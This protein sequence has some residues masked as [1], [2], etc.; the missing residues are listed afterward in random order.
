[1]PALELFLEPKKTLHLPADGNILLDPPLPNLKRVL[2][3]Q[4]SCM[5]R[6]API[7]GVEFAYLDTGAPLTIIPHRVWS[8]KYGWKAGR[9][10][11][12]LTTADGIALKGQVLDHHYTFRLAQL[13]VPVE[14]AGKNLKAKR[15]RIDSL[16]C[17]LADPGG[18]PFVI[19][20]LWGGIFEGRRLAIDRLPG[21]DEIQAILEW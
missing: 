10:F 7:P 17:Q 19:L 11:H 3:R 15:L 8:E 20:G 12:E 5:M 9:E 1:M 6:V 14:L 21:S 16:V 18:P 13:R 4:L 2:I